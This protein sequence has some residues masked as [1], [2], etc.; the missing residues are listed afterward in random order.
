MII[1][2]NGSGTRNRRKIIEV[3]RVP[4]V[5]CVIQQCAKNCDGDQKERLQPGA[6]THHARNP[7]HTWSNLLSVFFEVR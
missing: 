4:S 7:E 1:D 6:K 5:W 2:E 3:E